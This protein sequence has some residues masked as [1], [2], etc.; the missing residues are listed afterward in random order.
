M[1]HSKILLGVGL[2]SALFLSSCE[3]FFGSKTKTDFIE[4][5]NTNVKIIS[6]VPIQPVIKG[7]NNPTDICIGYDQLI[8][9]VDA[10]AEKIISY[11]ESG[12][13]LSEYSLNGVTAVAQDRKL[14]LIAIGKTDTTINGQSYKLSTLFRISLYNNGNYGLKYA[15]ILNKTVHPFYYKQ[16]FEDADAKTQFMQIAVLGSNKYYV[17]R[18]GPRNSVTQ[19]GGPDDAVLQFLESDKYLSPVLVETQTG[20]F[21]DYFRKPSGISALAQPPQSTNVNL[22]NDFVFTSIDINA[23]IK[24]QY[25]SRL[26]TDNGS[27]FNLKELT[28]GDTSKAEKFLYTPDRFNKPV[29]VTFGGDGANLIIVADSER[30]SVYIFG[31]NG[32]E[33]IKPPPGYN[34]TKYL[35]VSFG[36][37]G[38]GI[39]QFNR[40][41]AVAY[42]DEILYVADAG[43]N[44]ILRFK[45]TSDIQ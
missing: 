24:V 35:I 10:G 5:P 22:S 2:V 40:P 3:G 29:D 1:I 32:Y 30:D 42:K 7:L 15:R 37:A 6:Y 28:G 33:G 38:T 39:T 44:R 41:T 14:E 9:V 19:F 43:N 27:S 45:L 17:T 36:G 11:D 31:T 13:K 18:S 16:T 34:S 23:P 26:E 4:P 8:Y 12:N 25:I 20:L 21:Q